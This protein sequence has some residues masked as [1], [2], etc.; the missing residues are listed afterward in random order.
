VSERRPSP[1]GIVQER[2]FDLQV[3]RVAAPPGLPVGGS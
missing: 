1:L 2:T 3:Q